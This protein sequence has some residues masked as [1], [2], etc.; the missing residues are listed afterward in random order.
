MNE[1]ILEMRHICKYF[2]GV[3]ANDDVNF[4][5]YSGEIHALLGE[6]GAGKSTLMNILT[7]IY[8]PD[9]GEIVYQGKAH[10]L[11]SPKDAV[12]I[13]VGMV[14][15]HFRLVEPLT[16]TENV[17][18]GS[19]ACKSILK[20]DAMHQRVAQCSNEF[21]LE[22]DPKAKI[23][24]LSIGEQQRV[25][26]VKLL[27]RGAE[28]LILDEPT[29]VLT[30]QESHSLFTTLRKMADAGKAVVFISHKMYE[31]MTYSDRVTVL[32]DGKSIDTMLRADTDEVSLTKRMV[33]RELSVITP[34]EDVVRGELVLKMQGVHAEND[35]SLPALE[36]L[37]LEVYG[38]EIVGIAGVAGN[39]QKE[40]AEAIVGLRKIRSG[41]T[42]LCGQEI[43]QKTP[44]QI[45]NMG[46][47]FVP[48][49]RLGMGLVPN[50]S[51]VENTMLRDCESSASSRRGI[52][53][54]REVAKRTEEFVNAY[55]VKCAGIKRP[56]KLMSGGNQ[57]KLLLAR[58]IGGTPKLLITSYPVRGLDIG[59]TNAVHQILE[60]QRKNGVAVILI[61]ED[62][63]ELFQVSD[64]VAVLFKGK[65]TGVVER[66]N[67]SYDDVG[68]LMVGSSQKG[69]VSA[70]D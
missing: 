8:K 43:T 57:Q 41:K 22:V 30:P 64:R 65:I 40:L 15:Q 61:S 44:K 23:W 45:K 58:E 70:H 42:F 39:G 47:A 3:K 6:N 38:G 4:A 36:G 5:I 19:K 51:A 35:K 16:V 56:V 31:V 11:K 59:A 18:L 1:P 9:S 26:I 67:F 37:D 63:E 32:R 21:G 50:L 7:G 69:E 55:D 68:Y 28:I 20:L 46:V 13:G 53:K 33:G 27:F 12:A 54:F 17:Y 66:K 2:P 24:Q 25:E 49:D 52:I 10:P 29:A 60:N 34:N 62:L 14:H 48:E